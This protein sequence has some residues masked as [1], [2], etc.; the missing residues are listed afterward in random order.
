MCCD[1]TSIEGLCN[2]S[3]EVNTSEEN[4]KSVRVPTT[5]T[6]D[7]CICRWSILYL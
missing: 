2:E 1:V 5:V 7:P 4:D 6:L 3:P